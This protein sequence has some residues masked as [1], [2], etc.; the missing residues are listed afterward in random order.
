MVLLQKYSNFYLLKAS[1]K[2]LGCFYDTA[3]TR[4]WLSMCFSKQW[5]TCEKEATEGGWQETIDR[6]REL[7]HPT[8]CMTHTCTKGLLS[9]TR[10]PGSPWMSL[11]GMDDIL[12]PR[13]KPPVPSYLCT[14][15]PGGQNLQND[16]LW[17]SRTHHFSLLSHGRCSP[18]HST[19]ILQ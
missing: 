15:H 3:G 19:K 6:T 2:D 16:T 11:K 17:A 7:A 18:S 12:S 9:A 10:I 4:R 13:D 14:K 8:K 1:P 5:K